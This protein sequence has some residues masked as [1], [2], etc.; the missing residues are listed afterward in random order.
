MCMHA[1]GQLGS[2]CVLFRSYKFQMVLSMSMTPQTQ[3]NG[4]SSHQKS[5]LCTYVFGPAPCCC[6]VR[7]QST[8]T[9]PACG[10][11]AGSAF[12]SSSGRHFWR[13][14]CLRATKRR[15]ES[16]DGRGSTTGRRHWADH[17]RDDARRREVE[18]GRAGGLR[19]GNLPPTGRWRTWERVG[20][21]GNLGRGAL[22]TWVLCRIYIDLIL[23]VYGPAL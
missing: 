18:R 20:H 3:R 1:C 15:D 7:A 19:S 8:P 5:T 23:G 13:C 4:Q 9:S 22:F 17:G 10:G 16:D 12:A 21:P 2:M 14:T 6:H 11:R